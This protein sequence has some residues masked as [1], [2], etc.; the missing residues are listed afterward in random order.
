M[1][2]N[3][4]NPHKRALQIE[5]GADKLE[6]LFNKG[7]LCAAEIRCLNAESK[8]S[9]WRLCLSSCSKRMQANIFSFK[10]NAH[11]QKISKKCDEDSALNFNSGHDMCILSNR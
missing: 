8:Q 7:E 4:N 1:E 5:I 10:S 11:Y 9:L 6:L 2:L 3:K